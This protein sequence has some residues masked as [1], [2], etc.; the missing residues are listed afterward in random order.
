MFFTNLLEVSIGKDLG[1]L[2]GL[3]GILAY[4]RVS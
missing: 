3:N 2:K 4:H 1:P